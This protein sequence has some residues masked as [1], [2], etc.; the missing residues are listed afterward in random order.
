M[1]KK[2]KMGPFFLQMT[3][4]LEEKSLLL[5]VY[6]IKEIKIDISCE[7]FNIFNI[8]KNCN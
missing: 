2:D 5:T 4:T 6:T 1:A 8:V 3:G 7:Y